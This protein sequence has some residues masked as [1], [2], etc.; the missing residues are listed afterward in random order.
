MNYNTPGGKL[1]RG[2]SVVDTYQILIGKPLEEEVYLKVS[3]LGW[4]VELVA[5]HESR[6][7]Q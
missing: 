1:N 4:A 5:L 3:I 6:A 2:M 7:D